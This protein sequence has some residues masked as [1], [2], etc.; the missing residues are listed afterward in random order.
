MLEK[1]EVTAPKIP[2]VPGCGYPCGAAAIH[3][4]HGLRIN[5]W[6]TVFWLNQDAG[7]YKAVG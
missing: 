5:R 2:G 7:L 1:V 6:F 4:V 3:E